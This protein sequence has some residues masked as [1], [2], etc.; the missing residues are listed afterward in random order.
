MAGLCTGHGAVWDCACG[1]GQA[2][3]DLAARFDKVSRHRCECEADRRRPASPTCLLQCQQSREQRPGRRIGRSRDVAQAAHWFDL[4]RFYAEAQ[5]VL[6]TG[7]VLALWS[8]GRCTSRLRR[9]T[10]RCRV[11]I[12]I[13]SDL[14]GRPNGSSWMTGTAG[15]LSLIPRSLR[16]LADAAALAARAPHGLRAQ[17]VRQPGRYIEQHGKDPVIEL[18][19][20]LAPLWGDA[21]RERL[22]EWPLAV[23]VGRK[24]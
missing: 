15:F 5:R 19:A 12:T 24:P 20:Q 2:A 21:P 16:P 6:R 9:S 1:S 13:S 3:I 17:L 14:S 11:S 10:G 23:R 18:E 22:V 4:P 7:G 8:M